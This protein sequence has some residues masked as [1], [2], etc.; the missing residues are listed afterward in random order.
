LFSQSVWEVA[1]GRGEGYFDSLAGLVFF[2]LCGKLFQQKTWHRLSFD[3]DYKS[4]FPLSV[5]RRTSAGDESISIA[6]LRAGDRLLVR[7]GELIPA[8]ARL[9]SGPGLIDYSFVT[10]ESEP[11]GTEPG[12]YLASSRRHDRNRD[13][14]AAV[15]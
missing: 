11:V 13:D 15:A 1:S 14:R 7:H 4:F 5:T 9:V 8:D 3:R 10:G 12:D 2:L 6:Q